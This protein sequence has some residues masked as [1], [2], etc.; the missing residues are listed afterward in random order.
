LPQALQLF[1]HIPLQLW[2]QR[3]TLM[4]LLHLQLH[5]LQAMLFL[6]VLC[7]SHT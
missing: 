2:A 3:W 7:L 5:S 4:R 6:P 1:F